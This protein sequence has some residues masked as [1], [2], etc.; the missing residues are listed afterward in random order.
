MQEVGEYITLGLWLQVAAKEERYQLHMFDPDVC[1]RNQHVPTSWYVS[2]RRRRSTRVCRA[3]GPEKSKQEVRSLRRQEQAK[4]VA[5]AGILFLKSQMLTR[6]I[7][8][9]TQQCK[10]TKDELPL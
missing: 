5:K 7:Q 6:W 4:Y 3:F 2:R 1:R 9:A 8:Y 10:G